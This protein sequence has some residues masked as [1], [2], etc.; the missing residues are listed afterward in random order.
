MPDRPWTDEYTLLCEKCGYVIEGLDP[1]GNCPECGKPIA[2]SLPERRV[3]TPWQQS[4]GVGSLVRTWWMTL[5]HPVRTLDVMRVDSVSHPRKLGWGTVFVASLILAF[6]YTHPAI[7]QLTPIDITHGDYPNGYPRWNVL[8]LVPIF[9]AFPLVVF[10]IL[11]WIETRGLK[12]I[13]IT[14]G[15]RIDIYAAR[16]ITGHGTTGWLLLACWYAAAH[17]VGS[18]IIQLNTDLPDSQSVQK[19]EVDPV[20][21]YV[22]LFDSFAPSWMYA[23]NFYISITGVLFGFLFFETFAYLGLRRLKFANRVRPPAASEGTATRVED[24]L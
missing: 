24:A 2:E 16:N 22:Y 23:A 10:P 12:L 1:S 8:L 4:P 20:M 18:L 5:R 14:R 19:G 15:F 17:F 6:G 7:Y 11:T 3:G 9:T 13:A 21:V